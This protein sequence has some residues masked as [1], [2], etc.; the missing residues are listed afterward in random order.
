MIIALDAGHSLVTA[1]KRI[2]INIA[3]IVG[4]MHEWEFNSAVANKVANKLSEYENISTFRSDDTTGN[5]DIPLNTRVKNI[6]AKG[7]NLV[8]SI[9]ANAGGGTGIETFVYKKTLVGSMNV[10]TVIQR[11]IIAYTGLKDRG[12]KAD[13]F[14]IVRDTK[15]NAVLIECGFMDTL[16]DAKLL[17]SDG[18]REQVANSIIASLVELYGLKKKAT[19]N[20]VIPPVVINTPAKPIVNNTERTFAVG[21]TVYI[22]LLASRYVTG[23]KIPGFIK[24]RKHTIQQINLKQKKALLKEIQSWVYL[25]DLK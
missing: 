6:N 13:N 12:V 10:A 5:T 16:G 18:Y 4:N 7:A 25:A 24:L 17:V 8:I 19:V 14:A 11:N 1:G 9:H 21:N 20:V 3:N 2:P 23:E 22:K 15:M